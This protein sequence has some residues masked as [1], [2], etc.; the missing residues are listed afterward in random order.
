MHEYGGD[1]RK[2]ATPTTF[3]FVT[4]QPRSQASAKHVT[5]NRPRDLRNGTTSGAWTQNVHAK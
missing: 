4:E 5:P 3:I 1:G 2:S